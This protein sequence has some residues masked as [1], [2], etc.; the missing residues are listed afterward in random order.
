MFKFKKINNIKIDLSNDFCHVIPKIEKTIE[1]CNI[2]GEILKDPSG[3]PFWQKYPANVSFAR[4]FYINFQNECQIV[5]DSLYKIKPEILEALNEIG[6]L[7]ADI[8]FIPHKVGLMR[9][10]AGT[11]ILPHIDINRSI[12]INVGLKNSNSAITHVSDFKVENFWSNPLETYKMEDGDV[13][14]LNVKKT[15]A[16]KPA[17]E[18]NNLDR[19]IITYTLKI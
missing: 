3:I 5:A 6:I 16:V 13:Y 2:N 19:Y 18:N 14:L 1:S 12:C 7:N 9:I 11:S 10:P 4:N 17:D 8:K 15:H